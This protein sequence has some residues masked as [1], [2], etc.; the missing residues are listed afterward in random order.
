MI[1]LFIMFA[2][3]VVIFAVWAAIVGESFINVNTIRS[4]G[5]MM[6]VT[7]FLACGS[8][9]LM[10]S[11]NL[12]LSASAIGAF[13]SI[14]MGAALSYWGL[15]TPVAILLAI[16]TGTTFGIL[17]AV[18]V[19]EFN[20][21]PF[22]G[23][24]AMA[25]VVRGIMMRVSVHPVTNSPVDVVFSN[26]ATRWIANGT[27][28][29]V[30]AMLILAIIVFII[31]G[32]I[33]AKS[34]FG[35]Q[36][37]LIGGNRMAANLCGISPRK[38]IYVLFANSAFLASIA[39]IV[40]MGR[41]GAGRLEAM[42]GNQFTGL[43]AAILGGVSFGGGSGNMAGVFIGILLLNTFSM[44]TIVVRFNMYWAVIL[45]GVLLLFALGLDYYNV[46][47]ANKKLQ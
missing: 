19:Y 21:A 43:T 44:G 37:Y 15:P 34:K 47:K 1:T 20:F 27:I 7:A 2:A 24:M 46:R 17:N 30:P 16:I 39:G 8:G 9:F 33:L 29:G 18:L 31:Y 13:S 5:N 45:E 38:M 10:V 23:T 22:I 36:V 25:S 41:Q 14:M 11:G 28:L 3:V 12:D 32:L 42:I 26:A 6:V 40:F 4:I 35:M